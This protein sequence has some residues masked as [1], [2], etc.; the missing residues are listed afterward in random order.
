MEKTIIVRK[1]HICCNCDNKIGKGE[2]AIFLSERVPRFDIDDYQIG[3]EYLKWYFHTYNC[4]MSDECKKE[5]H[6]WVEETN[7]DDF[8]SPTGYEICIEC[9]EKRKTIHTLEVTP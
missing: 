1:D 8:G 9:G 3:I 5:N 7:H 2:K 6:Q 4:I